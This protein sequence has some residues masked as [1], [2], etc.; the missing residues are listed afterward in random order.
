MIEG[1]YMGVYSI[2]LKTISKVYVIAIKIG[3]CKSTQHA[4]HS[5]FASAAAAASA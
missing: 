2:A 1:V 4:Q 3:G 5:C